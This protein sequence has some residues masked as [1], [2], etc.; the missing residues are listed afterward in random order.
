[1]QDGTGHETVADYFPVLQQTLEEKSEEELS[2]GEEKIV[3]SDGINTNDSND[4]N[5]NHKINQTEEATKTSKA[6]TGPTEETMNDDKDEGEE[7]KEN[8][9]KKRRL[10]RT[11]ME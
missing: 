4:S 9:E 3:F 11:P 5:A 7:D 6:Y 2:A 1:M 10:I 8:E